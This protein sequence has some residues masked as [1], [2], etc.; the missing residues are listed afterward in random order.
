MP[1]AQLQKRARGTGG[2]G[3]INPMMM[4]MNPMMMMGVNPMQA[5]M[6]QVCFAL[7]HT[8]N[9][10]YLYSCCQAHS[11]KA[12]ICSGSGSVLVC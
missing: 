10:S 4:G 2:P 5:M 11:L 9:P 3:Q 12:Y 8:S 1:L 6:S 7:S